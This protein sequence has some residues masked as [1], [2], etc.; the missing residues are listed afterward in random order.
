MS[1][2]TKE[3]IQKEKLLPSE[4]FAWAEG[5]NLSYLKFFKFFL[6]LSNG[7]ISEKPS[8]C[9]EKILIAAR[10]KGK[11]SLEMMIYRSLNQSHKA[12]VGRH[13]NRSSSCTKLDRPRYPKCH[14]MGMQNGFILLFRKSKFRIKILFFILIFFFVELQMKFFTPC[15]RLH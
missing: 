13:T 12:N 7:L 14:L 11:I 10:S 9:P 1:P 6:G 5:K 8:E 2:N 15:W 4:V 3:V